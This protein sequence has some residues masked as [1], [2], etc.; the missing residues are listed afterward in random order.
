VLA[1]LQVQSVSPRYNNTWPRLDIIDLFHKRKLN[2]ANLEDNDPTD[3]IYSQ[4][5][6]FWSASNMMM[7]LTQE[8]V[9]LEKIQQ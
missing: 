4:V 9:R 1:S 3:L 7:Q 2:A 5:Q 8:L 6:M